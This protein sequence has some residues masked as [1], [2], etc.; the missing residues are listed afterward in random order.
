MIEH[1]PEEVHVAALPCRFRDHL[2]DRRD[3]AGMIV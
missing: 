3:Q 2:A 1:V